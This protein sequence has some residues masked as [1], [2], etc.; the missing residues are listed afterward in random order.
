MPRKTAY[1]QK[2]RNGAAKSFG[3]F[4]SQNCFFAL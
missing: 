4:T 1:R 3:F 2:A